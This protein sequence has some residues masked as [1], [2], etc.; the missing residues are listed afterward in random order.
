[1]E[2]WWLIRKRNEND[3]N[4]NVLIKRLKMPKKSVCINIYKVASVCFELALIAG[5]VTGYK[6]QRYGENIK[7]KKLSVEHTP[8]DTQSH[9]YPNLA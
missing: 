9:M 1:M 8:I 7:V 4:G 3:K 2:I 6:V 5:D